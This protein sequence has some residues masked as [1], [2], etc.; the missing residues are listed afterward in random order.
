MA[1][2]KPVNYKSIDMISNTGFWKID[3]A[4]FEDEHKYDV[5]LSN[6]IMT[7]AK[8]LNVTKTYDF[9]CGPGK[10]TAA[11]REAGIEATGLDGNPL[12]N[13]IPNCTVQDLTADFDLEPVNFLLSLEVCEHV[14][15]EFEAKLVSNINK[16]VAPGG[17]LVLSWAVVGQGGFG[18]VNCQNNDYVIRLFE[19]LGYTYDLENSTSLRNSSSLWWF[20]N[21]IMVFK[22]I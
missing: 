1:N 20:K 8:S 6:A 12:T 15:K 9:G 17:T 22:K 5:Q 19:G 10:Y 18:H 14:P 7:L 4:R 2:L 21:T 16:H 3:G 11:F 13:T